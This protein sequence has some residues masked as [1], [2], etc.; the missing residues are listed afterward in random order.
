M[1]PR[2]TSLPGG[3]AAVSGRRPRASE[4][5][6][7]LGGVE[8]VAA[9]ADLEGGVAVAQA[10]ERGVSGRLDRAAVARGDEDLGRR[11][12]GYADAER[13]VTVLEGPGGAHPAERGLDVG[14]GVREPADR[15]GLDLD[16]RVAGR[17]RLDPRDALVEPV[18]DRAQ[19]GM[20]VG[21]RAGLPLLPHR[22]GAEALE[23]V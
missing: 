17:R 3:A 1:G 20:V 19:E 18:V 9:G 4:G 7:L 22:R 14:R 10:G 8:H 6:S 16:L 2:A 11:A 5:G 21:A 15:I 13:E 23:P 12:D